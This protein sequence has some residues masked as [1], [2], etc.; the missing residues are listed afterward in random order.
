MGIKKEQIGVAIGQEQISLD[1]SE[2]AAPIMIGN[3]IRL[4]SKDMGGVSEFFIRDDANHEVQITDNGTAGGTSLT[5]ANTWLAEQTVPV[6]HLT[7]QASA[8]SSHALGDL[9]VNLSKTLYYYDGSD[10]VAWWVPPAMWIEERPIDD[11][12]YNWSCVAIGGDTS[13]IFLA[14]VDGGYVYKGIYSGGSTT[15]SPILPLGSN[16]WWSVASGYNGLIMI[17]VTNGGTPQLSLDGGT[18]WNWVTYFIPWWNW[19]FAI[20]GDNL[21][22]LGVGFNTD[23]VLSLDGGTTWNPITI[24]GIGVAGWGGC[25]VGRDPDVMVACNSTRAYFTDDQWATYT[26]LQPLGNVDVYWGRV[27]IG[28]DDQTIA[29]ITYDYP[30]TIFLTKN[31]GTSWTT[32][33]ISSI[34]GTGD[35]SCIALGGDGLQALVNFYGSRMYRADNLS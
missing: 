22:I 5:E 27:A 34:R 14:C 4:Y 1:L 9:Y 20:G 2:Q 3:K 17:A 33:D 8:P 21:T 30:N 7:P 12:D 10:W 11:N 31:R 18:T 15:W 32:I 24:A 29:L 35:I 26:E 19:T 6:L 25:G 16:S 13:P 23:P 28:G